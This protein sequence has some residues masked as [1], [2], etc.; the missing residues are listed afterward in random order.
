LLIL[1]D[2]LGAQ[3]NI[4]TTLAYLAGLMVNFTLNKVWTFSAPKGAKQSAKQAL[5][6]GVLVVFNLILTNAIVSGAAAVG[7]GPELSKPIATGAIMILNY[8]VYQRVIFRERP[9][10]EPFA[11]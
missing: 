11:G 9:P 4:A 2:V 8:V 7:I 5:Q 10:L 6:Y 1:H 3:L